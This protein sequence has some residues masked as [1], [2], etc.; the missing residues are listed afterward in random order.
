M[1]QTERWLPIPGF[2]GIY[3]ASSDGLVRREGR[4]SGRYRKRLWREPRILNPS[5]NSHGYLAVRLCDKAKKQQV[6]VHQLILLAFVGPCPEGLE[7]CHGDG[8]RRN[9][10]LDNLRYDTRSANALDSVAHGTSGRARGE[11]SSKAVLKEAEVLEIF[12]S[13][14]PHRKLGA[15]YGVS[16]HAVYGIKN[17][18][19]WKHL[20]EGLTP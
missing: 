2:E 5:V 19:T 18:R 11:I 14:L 10:R 12:H 16:G 17:R 7:V 15:L 6:Y 9:A 20:T 13:H 4:W 8:D 3:S 1:E